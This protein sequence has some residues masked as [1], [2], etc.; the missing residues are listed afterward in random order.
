MNPSATSRVFCGTKPVQPLSVACRMYCGACGPTGVGSASPPAACTPSSAAYLPDE[1][2]LAS[3]FVCV[4]QPPA[5]PGSV[6]LAEAGT[7]H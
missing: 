1:V 7:S 2:R 4:C 5:P 6:A 3:V